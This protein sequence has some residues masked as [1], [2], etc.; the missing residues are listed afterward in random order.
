M[1]ETPQRKIGSLSKR[2]RKP[3]TS[4]R[5]TDAAP[6]TPVS[7]SVPGVSETA[8][9]LEAEPAASAT[10]KV[11]IN[12]SV[13]RDLRTRARAAYRA[14]GYSS[15]YESFSDLVARALEHEVQRLE[16]EHNNGAPFP[17]G[18]S[19]LPSGRPMTT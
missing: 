19:A 16:Q 1:T 12:A 9:K 14:V 17:G 11:Q 7:T 13:P 6:A 3:V 10:R 5:E 4:P 15:G 2:E 18:E 8:P